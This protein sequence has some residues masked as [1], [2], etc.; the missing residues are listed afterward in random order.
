MN[1]EEIGFAKFPDLPFELR[2]QIWGEAMPAHGICLADC[3]AVLVR[4]DDDQDGHKTVRLSLKPAH[5]KFQVRG[6][7]ERVRAQKVLLATCAES[8]AELCK[9]FPET[10]GGSGPRFSF[11]HDLIYMVS[12]FVE[13][14]RVGP[15]PYPEVRLEFEGGWNEAVHRLALNFELW[16]RLFDLVRKPSWVAWRD[17]YC[18]LIK[19][20]M[21]FLTTCTSLRELVLAIPDG[22]GSDAWASMGRN[23]RMTLSKSMTDCYGGLT[24]QASEPYR[25]G[26]A[27]LDR[28]ALFLRQIIVDD[29]ELAM[30]RDWA[31]KLETGYPALRDLE[32]S[33]MVN[34]SA[35]LRWLCKDS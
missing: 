10:L 35:D 22:I 15:M 2:C 5:H 8:R 30:R 11:R 6:L 9:R 28:T 29:I 23:T 20:Q 18:P 16:E 1:R 32:I 19:T 25:L 3:D 7:R 13:R 33:K 24:C 12:D 34:V 27:N 21:E 31:D 17:W 26:L 14:A 4:G